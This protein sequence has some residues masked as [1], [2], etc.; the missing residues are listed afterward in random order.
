MAVA[1]MPQGW[2]YDWATV[3][4]VSDTVGVNNGRLCMGLT[5][6]D[7]GC[8]ANAP[9]LNANGDLTVYGNLNVSGSQ[10]FQGVTFA[11]GGVSATGAITATTFY[12]NGSGITGIDFSANPVDWYNLLRIPQQVQEVSN[13]GAIVM[14]GIS[15]TNVSVTSNLTATG[16]FATTGTFSSVAANTLSSTLVSASNVSA[17]Y[18]DATRNGTVSATN[19]YFRYISGSVVNGT[20]VGDGSGLTG[21]TAASADRI[22]S[23]TAQVIA[24]G[25]TNSISITESGVTTG[26][27]YGGQWVAGSISTTGAGK[28]NDVSVTRNANVGNNLTVAGHTVTANVSTTGDVSITG[29]LSAANFIGDGSQLTNISASNIVGLTADRITSGTTNVV[30]TQNQSIT[31]TTAGAQRLTIDTNGNVGISTTNPREKLT[32]DGS[33]LLSAD[34]AI[35]GNVYWDG[36]TYRNYSAGYGQTMIMNSSLG[37]LIFGNTATS[38]AANAAATILTRM[39]MDPSG[40]VALGGGIYPSATLDVSGTLKIANGGEACDASRLGAIKY[41]S[42]SFYICQDVA[43]NWEPLATLGAFSASDRITSGT[44][45]VITNSPAN[46]ISFTVGGVTTGYF[47]NGQLVASGVSTT[48]AGKFNNVSVTANADIGGNL[49]ATGIAAT[50]AVSANQVSATNISATYIDATRGGTV[51]ATNGYFTNISATR[52]YGD[53]SGLTGVTA[54]SADRII[55]GTAQVIANG[56]TNSISITEAGVTTAYYYNG[57]WV[58]G[59]VS[60]TGPIST[61]GLYV[62][63]TTSLNGTTTLN[64]VQFSFNGP[65]GNFLI[66]R[67]NMSGSNNTSMGYGALSS[68]SNGGS[69]VAIGN[70]AMQTSSNGANNVAVGY[71]AGT[72]SSGQR[73]VLVGKQAGLGVNGSSSFSDAVLLGN[74]AGAGLT[75]GSSNTIIGS[76]AARTLTTGANNIIIGANVQ[77]YSD[78][79][80][81]QLNIG[82]AIYGDMGSATN[83]ANKIGINVPS[84]TANLEV[85]GT[86]SGTLLTGK[87]VGDGSGLTG[88]IAAGSD[89]ITSNTIKVIA[90]SS[91]N[92][93]SITESG[94]TTGYYYNGIWVAGGVSTTG[95]ISATTGYINN[96]LGLGTTNPSYTLNVSGSSYFY[97][98]SGVTVGASGLGNGNAQYNFVTKGGPGGLSGSNVGW[99]MYGRSD[100]Y[101]SSVEQ[102]DLGIASY[103]GNTFHIYFNLDSLTGN[104]GLGT[105][106]PQT[107]LDVKG[108]IRIGAETSTTLATCDTNRLGAIKYQSGAFYICQDV[109]HDWEPIATTGAFAAADRITSGTTNVITNGTGNSISFTVAGVTTGY[110]Y[111][112]QLVANGVSTTGAGKFNNVSVSTNVS[113]TG[114]VSANKFIGDGSLLTGIATNLSETIAINDLSDASASTAISSVFLGNGGGNH[115]TTGTQNTAVGDSALAANTTGSQN[116]AFGQNALTNNTTG[117]NNLAVGTSSMFS[118]VGGSTNTAVGGSSL[119]NFTTGSANAVVGNSGLAFVKAG[120]NNAVLGASAGWGIGSTSVDNSVL[121]GYQAGYNISGTTSNNILIGYQAG[122]NGGTGSN[123]LLIGA[124]VNAPTTTSSYALNLGNSLFGNMTN[125]AAGIGGGAKLG[126]NWVTPSVALEVSGTISATRFVGNGS[127]LTGI[128][129]NLSET[130]AI[131][132]LTDASASLVKNSVFLGNGSG[133]VSTGNY[134]TAVGVSALASNTT[135]ANN[136]ATGFRALYANTSGNANTANGYLALYSNTVGINNVANGAGALQ[137]NQTGGNNAANGA[138]ALQSNVTGGDNVAN[139]S[140]ALFS[141][142]TGNNNVANGSQALYSNTSGG[143]NTATG[144]QAMYYNVTGTDNTATGYS[145]LGSNVGGTTN[146]ANGVYALYYPTTVTGTVAIGYNAGQGNGSTGYS[147]GTYVGTASGFS[148][149]TGNYNTFYGAYSGDSVTTGAHNIVIG[150]DVDTPAPG[151]SDYL[152]IGN[153]ISGSLLTGGSLTFIGGIKAN[154]IVT[155]TYFE[156]DGSHLTGLATTNLSETIAI[157]DLKDASS[158]VSSGNMFLGQ[159]GGNTIT[160]GTNNTAIGIGA[161]VS[162]TI[163]ASNVAVGSSAL[164]KTTGAN[165]NIAIGATALYSNVNGGG[166]VG[167]GGGSL[168]SNSGGFSNVG[169]GFNALINSVSGNYNAGLGAYSLYAMTSGAGNVAMGYYAGFGSSGALNNNTFLG[170]YSGQAITT[171]NANTF[172]GYNA[173]GG[174]TTGSSNTVIGALTSPYS[175]TGSNQLAIANAIWGNIGSGTGNANLIGI[176]VTSPTANLEVSGTVSA[177]RFVGDGSGLTNLAAANLSETISINDLSDASASTVNGSVFLGSG[178]GNNNTGILNTALGYNALAANTSGRYNTAVGG[179]AGQAITTGVSNTAVGINTL[180]QATTG[181]NNTAIGGAA[182]QFGNPSASTAIGSFAGTGAP[183]SNQQFGTFIGYGAGDNATTGSANTYTGAYA[184]NDNTTGALNVGNGYGALQWG[185]PNNSVGVGAY[186]G[187]GVNGSTNFKNGT[188]VGYSSGLAITTGNGNTFLGYYAGATTTTGSSNTLIG[189]LAYAPTAGTSN[190]LNIANAISGSATTGGS[191]T[192]IGGIKANGIVTATYFEGDGSR[193]T[194]LA[195]AFVA[196]RIISGTAQVIANGATNSISITEA[197]VTTGYYY[198]G[199]WV[200]GSISTT[201]IGKFNSV[202]VTTG[203]YFGGLVGVGTL[204]PATAL[205]VSGSIKISNGGETCGAGKY[206]TMRV[207]NGVLSLCRQ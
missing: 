151:V 50:G 132:D 147:Y 99:T 184:G 142:T 38:G 114:N 6:G 139:G 206:G 128:A 18:V 91:S 3:A 189:A 103:D 156:G 27:Y 64:G 72:Y 110:F 92:S 97:G 192:F 163:G 135:G 61:T 170:S 136:A 127:G 157:N 98:G 59:G 22:I 11:N 24:N 48:G 125:A 93:V 197:G 149:T 33:I 63:G 26:Y 77:P 40:K 181:N 81:N 7:I 31:F 190:W 182:L 169:I 174:V 15:A 144:V 123:N 126:I 195:A 146:V 58:A 57:I 86:I 129:T 105:V 34:N 68:T 28:F 152:N 177:T 120:S 155:A 167:I 36:A 14:A 39:V 52:F 200:A 205:D 89:R 75:T 196:D 198:G 82:N 131:N 106:D 80:S 187:L 122:Y 9:S 21:V 148:V 153:A 134:N 162:L 35:R 2:A 204:A 19:G 100:A 145:A 67:G 118:N 53:G 73:N 41:Q 74:M 178:S 173:G 47:Y 1:A 203:G 83:N 60:T 141:N 137:N 185:T 17:T 88:V 179:H 111:N 76:N 56:N 23:G 140:A 49:T 171:A 4:T 186:A 124:G 201:G 101:S 10:I 166:N 116:A 43:H 20:F 70:Y 45:N 69:N 193:L 108:S 165:Q 168:W 160:T 66:G 159:G 158:T 71:G 133:A 207:I 29:N 25:S 202:S 54:A 51:S 119:I 154:G 191:M 42:N 16:L 138:N 113:V 117:N 183:T 172:V 96:H 13:S 161:A 37:Y 107:N 194:N 180:I 55:S 130:I 87:F 44:T 121:I 8:P 46:S 199:Q 94:V 143:H 84:P 65:A 176:N 79:G 150:Y 188:F 32:V 112:G 95:P 62:T 109:S 12:G 5:R 85:S 102:N 175:N 115:N 78:T 30:A 164:A 104:L 90:N